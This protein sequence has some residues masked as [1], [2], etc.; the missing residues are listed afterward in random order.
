MSLSS[1]E[2]RT[3]PITATTSG[4]AAG[5]L[6]WSLRGNAAFSTCCGVVFLAASG[7]LAAAAGISAPILVSSFGLNLVVFAVF[8]V[9]LASREMPR[10]S[11]AVAVVGLDLF[12]VIG[13]WALAVSGLLN[14]TGS[15]A[16]A[17]LSLPVLGFAAAQ[18]AGVR[19]LH[20]RQVQP[21]ARLSPAS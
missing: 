8:L 17:A 19:Q 10:I 2:T 14:D 21:T 3:T 1:D 20:L 16:L 11:L 5:L 6:R 12:C 18:T 4:D 15:A 13:F 7:S 9:W